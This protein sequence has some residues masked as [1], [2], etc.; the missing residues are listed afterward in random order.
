MF[1]E[2]LDYCNGADTTI[3]AN[4]ECTIPLSSLT[5]EPFSLTLDNEIQFQVNAHNAYGSSGFSLIGDGA[6]IQ[7]VPD[8]PV[9]LTDNVDRTSAT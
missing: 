9:L 1:I 6:L 7:L 4:T 5:S 3:V 8:A 2:N